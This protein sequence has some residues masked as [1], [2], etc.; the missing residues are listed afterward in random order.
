VHAAALCG[1]TRA[2]ILHGVRNPADRPKIVAALNLFPQLTIPDAIWDQ[3]GDNLAALRAAGLRFPFPDV[4][5]ATVA[6][7]YDIEL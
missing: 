2:E 7:A 5:L 3:V 1:I 4:V 6:M